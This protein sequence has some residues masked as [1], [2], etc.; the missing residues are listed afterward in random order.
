MNF[1]FTSFWISINNVPLACMTELFAREWGKRIGKL[2]DIKLVNGTMKVRVR[3]NITEPLKRGLRVAVD[4]QGNEVSLL[5]QYEHL[6][7]FCFDC[8]IIGHKALD[9]PLRD[10]GGD[11]PRPDRG[12]YGS[13]M[14]APSSPPRDRFRYQKK[15]D[16]SPSNRPIMSMG[17]A[18][19]I[20][21]AVEKGRVRYLGPSQ[22]ELAPT[23]MLEARE[24]EDEGK[25]GL[26][27]TVHHGSHSAV[28]SFDVQAEA[29]GVQSTTVGTWVEVVSKNDR[30]VGKVMSTC[31][32]GVTTEA[33]ADVIAIHGA[34]GECSRVHAI[35]DC[36]T[37]KCLMEGECSMDVASGFVAGKATDSGVGKVKHH[38]MHG[39]NSVDKGKGVMDIS[40]QVEF[41]FTQA[42]QETFEPLIHAQKAKTWKRLNSSRGRGSKGKPSSIP[43]SPKL[44]HVLVANAKNK[45]SPKVGGG[46]KRKMD[47]D[48][49][50]ENSGGLLLLWNDDWE[51]S[52]KS[53]SVGHIDALV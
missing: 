15:R 12:R 10:F 18:S 45:V 24:R 39:L 26:D 44:S 21:V 5:F 23:A 30:E 1:D 7:D 33:L 47:V 46:G 35:P 37:G 50:Y 28:P 13:W 43:I 31:E 17:E 27:A 40:S 49:H 19:R 8:G 36:G 53:F 48:V 11:N 4:E 16:N 14:C 9:C 3:M 25:S 41:S 20:L 34:G 32:M 38:S 6:P 2:E 51:V 52:V 29:L 22:E 42:L